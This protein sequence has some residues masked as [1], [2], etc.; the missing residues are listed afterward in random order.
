MSGP[1]RL[2]AL[3]QPAI[4]GADE[5]IRT[6]VPALRYKGKAVVGFGA[7][8]PHVALYVMFGDALR[9]L[10]HE[11]AEIDARAPVTKRSGPERSHRR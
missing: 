8:Q 1:A 5:T 11:L 3:L 7:G 6:R 4:P 9:A 10:R 2:P